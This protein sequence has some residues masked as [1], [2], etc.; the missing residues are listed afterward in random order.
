[1]SE[2]GKFV[3]ETFNDGLSPAINADRLN[4][5]ERVV[6]LAD[7]EL[8]ISKTKKLSDMIEYFL[9]RNTRDIAVFYNSDFFTNAY[10]T[11][12]TIST[13]SESDVII[14]N[15]GTKSTAIVATEGW[16]SFYMLGAD[17]DFSTFLDGGAS[18]NDDFILALVYVSDAA[19]FNE[20]EFR[21]GADGSNIYFWQTYGN[22]S[23][24]TGW[25]VIMMKKGDFSAESGSPNW[26]DVDYIRVSPYLKAGYSG[27][28]IIVNYLEMVRVDPNNV[29][30]ANPFQIYKGVTSG[31]ENVYD[32]VNVSNQYFMLYRD[33]NATIAKIGLMKPMGGNN[34]ILL[35]LYC[36]IMEFI[37]KFELYCKHAGESISITWYVDSNNYAETYISGNTFYLDVYEASVKSTVSRALTNN[38]LKN[39]IVYIKFEKIDDTFRAILEKRGD[40]NNVLEY[41]TSISSSSDGCLYLGQSKSD[42]TS[43]SL[44][45]DFEIGYKVIR[46]SLPSENFATF[47]RKSEEQNFNSTTLTDID[48]MVIL[49]PPYS[50]F[51][52]E[53][54]LI[55]KCDSSS[56]EFR[57]QWDVTNAVNLT[58]RMCFGPSRTNE[59]VAN[60]RLRMSYYAFN[61]SVPYGCDGS[62]NESIAFESAFF[63]TG[64]NTGKIQIKGSQWYSYPSNPVIVRAKS[65]IVI[66]KIK[67]QAT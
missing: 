54:N 13:V 65:S 57:V 31:W 67:G 1:M 51:K 16:L 4:E 32:L 28:Y 29:D 39:E 18:S 62:D 60:T 47:V 9:F 15:S 40:Y 63:K 42:N 53:V 55:F 17:F 36:S 21:F 26:N 43:L 30:W 56:P 44:I 7:Q 10:P 41:E 11:R 12:A 37:S 8:A 33:Y 23:I 66:T 19:A 45:T 49:L 52:V 46:N 38:L 3:Q 2:F 34:E 24:V 48:D 61:T 58:Y 27:E 50:M 35:H 5:L 59:D 22:Y 6:A 64:N 25:N 20:I 14:G